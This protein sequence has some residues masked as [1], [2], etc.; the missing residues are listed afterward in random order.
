MTR[1]GVMLAA[2]MV[3]L[4]ACDETT[5]SGGAG[6]PFISPLPERIVEIADPKQD[7]NAVKVDPVDGCL[8]YRHVGPVETTFLPLRTRQGRPICTQ[9]QEEAAPATT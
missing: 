1:T 6:G 4:A 5:Q 2:A 7:L 9:V 8:V 3:M